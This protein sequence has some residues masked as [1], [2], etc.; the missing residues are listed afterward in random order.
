MSLIVLFTRNF[1]KNHTIFSH[2]GKDMPV[3]MKSAGMSSSAIIGIVI[4]AILIV[5]IVV[6][7]TCFCVNRTGVIALL[8]DHSK[9]KQHDEEDPKLGR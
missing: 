2:T 3:P 4:G 8:C 9:S 5:L 7:I 1:I 6:D